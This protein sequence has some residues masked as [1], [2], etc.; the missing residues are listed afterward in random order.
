[1]KISKKI[2]LITMGDPHGIGPEICAQMLSSPDFNTAFIPV[3][4]GDAEI[5][6][7][8]LDLIKSSAKLKVISELGDVQSHGKDQ[9]LLWEP[10]KYKGEFKAGKICSLAGAASIAWVREAVLAIQG[11]KAVAMVTA[12]I[13][14]E[15]I[16]PTV[17]GF[18]GHTEYIGE[19]CDEPSPV[20]TLVHKNWVISHVS[21]HVSLR[22]A[23]DRVKIPRIEKT[24]LLL[25][26]FLQKYR[27]IEKPRIGVAGLNPHAGEDG[28]FGKEEVEEIAP[29]VQ[30]LLDKGLNVAGPIPG[31]VIFPQLRA[32]LFDGVVAMYHDQ[33]HIVTKTMLFGLGEQRKTAGVNLSLGLPVLRTSVD[34]GTGFDIAWQGKADANSLIDAYE[35]AE[36]LSENND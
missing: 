4:V 31:D 27:G 21:T 12:P 3:V 6:R 36:V 20:L 26:E 29:A 2:I 30:K 11:E 8:A 1:M 5:M 22:E 25:H 19:M 23:C 28:L 17:P 7:S 33:G 16:A 18:Q 34:H 13:S 32:E 9:I 35:L 10:L 24:A 14:K 15:S